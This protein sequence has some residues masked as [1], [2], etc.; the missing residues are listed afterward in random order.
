M[1]L[2]DS[3]L[4]DEVRNRL[5]QARLAVEEYEE[6]NRTLITMNERLRQS[7]ALKSNFLSNIRN[8]I[9]NPLNSIMGLA[10]EIIWGLDD[11]HPLA[12]V[13]EVI[14]EE[15]QNLNF[16]LTNIM[17]A[18]DLESGDYAANLSQVN[19][20]SLMEGV[21]DTFLPHIAR[22]KLK[23][24]WAGK[25]KDPIMFVSDAEKVAIL[26]ANLLDN[27]IKFS[28]DGKEILID[29]SSHDEKLSMSIR[30]SG[31]GIKEEDQKRIFDRFFQLDS[32]STRAHRG[33]GIGLSIVGALV[34]LLNG[35]LQLES[36]PGKGTGVTVL[37]PMPELQEDMDIFADEGNLLIFG[38]HNEK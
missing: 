2:N 17:T 32:G 23:I 37:F 27:A 16:Q 33:H 5:A 24:K 29:A 1:Q 12:S 14:R 9:N 30:D 20:T 6:A 28:N 13:A 25:T 11:D 8:E 3:E 10:S 21:I 36:A 34:D 7:E 38:Q 4:I 35:S 18:A 15:A 19:V 22:K 26:F 31:I